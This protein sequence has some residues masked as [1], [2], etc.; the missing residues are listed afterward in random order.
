MKLWN[1]KYLHDK[2]KDTWKTEL[3]QNLKNKQ[4]EY[5]IHIF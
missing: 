2:S 5:W 4:N 3:N 1:L